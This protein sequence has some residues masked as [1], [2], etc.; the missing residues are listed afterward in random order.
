[1]YCWKM[2]IDARVSRFSLPKPPK[3]RMRLHFK[4]LA[5][6]IYSSNL[7]LQSS[8]TLRDHSTGMIVANDFGLQSLRVLAWWIICQNKPSKIRKSD[9]FVH[10]QANLLSGFNWPSA[11]I[12]GKKLLTTSQHEIGSNTTTFKLTLFRFLWFDY[13]EFW[14]KSRSPKFFGWVWFQHYQWY[15]NQREAFVPLVIDKPSER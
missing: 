14:K 10:R 13:S 3:I 9:S 1:M 15:R 12:K 4:L 8:W 5:F 2:R 6:K 7:A 11:R